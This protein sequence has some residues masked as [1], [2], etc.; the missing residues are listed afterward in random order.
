MP[1]N[2]QTMD[3]FVAVA[4]ERSFTR[5]A[6]RLHVT[7]QTLSAHIA[8]T[9]RE[10]G[11]RLLYRKVPLGLTAAGERFLV[12]A[13]GFQASQRTMEQEFRD[14]A[15]DRRGTLAVG[16]AGTRGLLHMPDAISAFAKTHPGIDVHLREGENDELLGYLRTQT[17]DM[18]VA[19]VP[20]G[21]RGLEVRPLY[22]E[23]VAML[24]T[25][26]LLAARLGAGH[27]RVTERLARTGDLSLVEGLPLLVLGRADRTSDP[28]RRAFERQGVTP[29]ERVK[30][31][32]AQTLAELAARGVGACF[33]PE[34]LARRAAEAHPEA[35]LAVIPMPQEMDLS[36]SV[37]WR[38]GEH[39][40]SVVEDFAGLLA[41]QLGD[42]ARGGEKGNA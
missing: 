23:R 22:T 26:G 17:V 36:I 42:A 39:T 5:A 33:V 13:R 28:A 31:K 7:Q 21:E 11:V 12:Y 9:E 8:N 40:W 19:S 18:V 1:V 20:E 2:F 24:A 37:A 3:Y 32:N 14:I 41:S 6:E 25:E 27:A 35:G 38:S 30:S 29:W 34:G 10:L 16:I 15:G 4:E